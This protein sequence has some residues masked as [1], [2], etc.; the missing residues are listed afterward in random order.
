MYLGARCARHG[1]S[2]MIQRGDRCDL[3]VFQRGRRLLEHLLNEDR[4]IPVAF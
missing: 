3:R 4:A 1:W 2:R